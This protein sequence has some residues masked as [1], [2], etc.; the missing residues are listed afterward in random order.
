MQD[1]P[2]QPIAVVE[3][4]INPRVVLFHSPA[5]REAEQFRGLRNS[6]LAMNPDR[7]PRSV[8]LVASTSGEG[9]STSCVNLAIALA[10]LAGTRVLL[11]DANLRQPGLEQILAMPGHPGLADVLSDKYSPSNAIRPTL[12]KGVD[13]LSAGRLPENPAELLA[14]GRLQPLL[15]ALKPDYS[16]II[17]D[18]PPASESTDASLISRE[19]DGVIFVVRLEM[20]PRT[21]VEDSVTQLR[22]LGANLLGTFLVGVSGGKSAAIDSANA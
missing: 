21:I 9:S 11:M 22:A 3:R 6:I 5:S 16:Y 8:A 19:C 12:I 7:A 20:A 1:T 13:L 17:L 4:A 15:H 2:I 18:T 14:K 10:E